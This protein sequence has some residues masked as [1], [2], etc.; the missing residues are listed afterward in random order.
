MKTR[1][2]KIAR[3]FK[4]H[5]SEVVEFLRVNGYECEEDPE[6]EFSS[7]VAEFIENNFPAFLSERYKENLSQVPKKKEKNTDTI[8]SEQVPLE[9]K[10]IDSASKEKKLIERI[11]GFTEF[12][13]HYTI[14]KFKGTCSQPV[15]FNLFDEVL[16]DLLLTEQMS[17]EKIGNILGFDIE[18]DP[19]ENDILLKAIKDL[20]ADKMLDGDESILWLTNVGIEYAKNGVKFSTF[21]R[22]FDLYIDSIGVSKEKVKEIFSNLKSEK[23]PNFNKDFLPKNI[24]EVKP[25]AELQA[26]EIHF[27]KKNFLLQECKP[28]AAE[29]FKAKVWVVLLE[30]FRDNTLRAIVYDEKQNK[31]IDT[32]SE[33]LDKQD[34]LKSELL[35]RLVKV[36][37]EIEFTNEEKQKEQV[38]IELA[39]IN[40]QE[41]I[42]EAIKRQ[43]T[44]KIKEIEKEVEAIKR[45]FNSLEFEVELKKLFDTT[46]DTIL[47]QSPWV[48]NFA[49]KNRVPFIK[50]YLRKGGRVYIAYSENESFGGEDMVQEESKKL[51]AELDKN[52]N[53][54]CCELPAFHY[55]NVWLMRKNKENS[56]YSGSYNILSFFVHQN[57]KNVR[58]EK[59]T[60]M[61]WDSELEEQYLEVFKKFGLKY[62]NSAIEDFN[63]L[64]QNPPAKINR[65]YL[66]KL[67]KVENTKLS[68]FKGIGVAEFDSALGTLEETKTENLNHYRKIFFESEI[69]RYKKQVIE[70]FHKPLSPDR[71]K[72][73]QNE[74]EKLREEFLDFLDLQI[75]KG[76]EVT[77]MINNLKVFIPKHQK[78]HNHNK[79]KKRR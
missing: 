65:E 49:F 2:S 50:E 43:D 17:A 58:Q 21:T 25:I 70:L 79:N 63:T 61:G 60:R 57:M 78:Q 55:K 35:E 54:Y 5:I 64:C 12:D 62:I 15:D 39:L 37:D 48:R 13:W 14:A 16:C 23:T 20:K 19:A 46:S 40:K 66:Q 4:S 27:P 47:I 22:D 67:R 75:S 44:V 9:L 10:I 76:T 71:K 52:L 68:P 31:V 26:P 1:L 72:S 51:L 73:L 59:M 45:H 56:Y 41:E 11:I 74:F 28:T 69:E 77:D 42:E 33:A 3:D 6:V 38:E 18:K 7:E 32:L 24:E 34:E 29:G 53:F 30:N 8:P 36:D